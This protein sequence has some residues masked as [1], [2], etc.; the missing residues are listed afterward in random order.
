[1]TILERAPL[2]SPGAVRRSGPPLGLWWLSPVGAM[3]IVAPA[4]LLGAWLIGDARYRSEWRTPKELTGSFTVL[5]LLGLVAFVLGAAWWQLRSPVVWR[6][7]WP[8]L[9]TRD[10]AV[11]QRAGTWTFRATLFGY[12]ALAAIGAARGV[13]PATLLHSFATQTTSDT[14]KDSFAPIAGVSSFTQVGIAHVVVAGLLFRRRR[15]PAWGIP[16][17]L[18]RRR[19]IV[20]LI[21]GMLRAFLLSERLALL[22]LVVPLL[23]IAVLRLSV[24]AGRRVRAGFRLAPAVLLPMLLA[25]FG[26]FEYSRSWQFYRSHGGTSFWDFA[27]VRFAGYYATSYNNAAIAQAHASFPGRLPYSVIEFIWTAPGISQLN[28]YDLLSGGD[29]QEAFATAIGQYGN[30]EFNN[31]GGLGAPFLDLGAV[32]GLLFFL[33]L[34]A[35]SGWCWSRLRAGR[36]IGMLLY[37]ALLTGLFE[38]PRYLY[39]SQGRVL[40]ALVVLV[41]IALRLERGRPARAAQRVG[42]RLRVGRPEPRAAGRPTGDPRRTVQL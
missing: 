10:R 1:V 4:S 38:M 11:L 26:A 2:A 42:S 14:L 9:S 32:G 15:D 35:L 8:A 17:R 33:G 23:T 19:L 37:P 24:A 13:S 39:L 41:L 12:V 25:V 7:R 6:G 28:L 40:P 3:L 29:A 36:P 31:P 20:I 30:P 27:I 18:V 5:M 22:E 21:L 16:D 34:G